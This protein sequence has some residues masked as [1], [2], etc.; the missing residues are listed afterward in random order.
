MSN[1][2]PRRELRIRSKLRIEKSLYTVFVLDTS[3]SMNDCLTVKTA[4]GNTKQVKKIDELN[5]SV[6]EALSRLRQYE[7]RS[8]R[9]TFRYQIINLNSD[10]N[11]LFSGYK[12][13]SKKSRIRLAA[14]GDTC[15]EKSLEML[16]KQIMKTALSQ[17]YGSR[18]NV[19]LISDGYPTDS[20]GYVQDEEVYKKTISEFKKK[21]ADMG[22]RQYVRFYSI[23][24]GDQ[25]SEQ[26][27]TGFA[28]DGDYYTTDEERPLPQ[29]LCEVIQKS[30]ERLRLYKP[31]LIART[32]NAK[33]FE[34][35]KVRFE[36][37][38]FE[39][40]LKRI[41]IVTKPGVLKKS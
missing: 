10:G 26:M 14:K 35:P 28:D 12:P 1:F 4:D 40:E 31:E 29:T 34:F 22:Y 9:I 3:S 2:K 23:S 41:S 38:D 30:V 8:G 33:A 16:K 19:I 36:R 24:V 7:A 37:A 11:A 6:E 39:E 18:I 32:D 21:I 20:D 15:L 13:V 17:N 5:K 27:L 25:A